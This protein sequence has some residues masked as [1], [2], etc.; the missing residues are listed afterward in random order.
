MPTDEHYGKIADFAFAEAPP[1]F[2]NV[3]SKD[4][5]FLTNRLID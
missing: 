2:T 4:N 1:I 5:I 3:V